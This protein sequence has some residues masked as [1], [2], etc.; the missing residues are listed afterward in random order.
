MK[1]VIV[2]S[3]IFLQYLSYFY[4]DE[5]IHILSKY[6]DVEWMIF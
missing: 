2:N 3:I 4:T 5:I 1:N 6:G